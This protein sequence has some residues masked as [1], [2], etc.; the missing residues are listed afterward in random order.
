[1]QA[2]FC[3]GCSLR[4]GYPAGFHAPTCYVV[5]GGIV[6]VHRLEYIFTGYR[7]TRMITHAIGR[8]DEQKR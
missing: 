2:S 6:E 1:M 5:I 8:A 7:A 4:C 3:M